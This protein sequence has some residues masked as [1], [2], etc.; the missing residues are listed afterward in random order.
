LDPFAFRGADLNIV[1]A[2]N[3]IEIDALNDLKV[4]NDTITSSLQNDR[5]LVQSRYK[6]LITDYDQQRAHL[7]ESLLDRENLRKEIEA[8]NK[9]KPAVNPEL[10][11]EDNSSTANAQLAEDQTKL[12]LQSLKEVSR[13]NDSPKE[14]PP[15]K[16]GQGALGRFRNLF[17]RPKDPYI[18]KPEPLRLPLQS[19][20]ETLEAIE[21]AYERQAIGTL[22]RVKPA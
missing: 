3:E 21:L 11:V 16:K 1:A 4:A 17:S 19:D 22:Q 2:M 7:V 5:Q 14:K 10:N 6:N 18:P 15:Q 20:K 8:I 9:G 13:K 12:A